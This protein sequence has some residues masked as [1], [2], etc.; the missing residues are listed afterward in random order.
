M[1]TI[2]P[3]ARNCPNGR[4]RP[5]QV[6]RFLAAAALAGMAAC[7][8]ENAIHSHAPAPTERGP[9]EPDSRVSFI[10]LA[11]GAPGTAV[12]DEVRATL[13]ILDNTGN[14]VWKWSD[15]SGLA[16]AP[17]A[18]LPT[19]VSA[20]GTLPANVTLGQA[21]LLPDGTLVVNRFGRAGGAMGGIAVV[22]PD[23]TTMLVPNL[24]ESR[25]RLG[26]AVA[27]DGTL[28]GSFFAKGDSGV[29]GSVTTIDLRAG[30]TVIAEGFGKIAGLAVSAGRLFVSDQSNGTIRDAPLSALPPLAS[31]WHTLASLPKPDQICAGPDGSLFSG[32]FQAVPGSSDAVAVRCISATGTVTMFRT[33]PDVSRPTGVCYDA[34][35]RRLFVV[36]PGNSAQIGVHVFEVP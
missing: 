14:R 8:S 23:G 30:E 10:P 19:P 13:Y 20:G 17:Y 2:C 16:S 35:N 12:W 7:G 22:A 33:D 15:G 27:P 4:G 3:P 21:A 32:Q 6:S 26:L 18:S 11:G 31:E 28:Y 1:R 9:R 24:D 25:R 36:D 29:T 34:R 5:G